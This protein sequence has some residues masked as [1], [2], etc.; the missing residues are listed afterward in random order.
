MVTLTSPSPVASA[1]PTRRLAALALALCLLT[2]LTHAATLDLDQLASDEL[3]VFNTVEVEGFVFSNDGRDGDG[4]GVWPSGDAR[5]V[6]RQGAGIL[7]HRAH[8]LTSIEHRDD[9]PFELM[10]M[11]VSDGQASGRSIELEFIYTDVEGAQWVEVAHLNPGARATTLFFSSG[12]VRR[13]SWRVVTPDHGWCQ[14]DNVQ[15]RVADA[16]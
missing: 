9:A 3:R 12:L 7:V 14:I 15:V 5:A 8:T 1:S 4:L 11:E 16:H 10:S 6:D 2:P 13:V